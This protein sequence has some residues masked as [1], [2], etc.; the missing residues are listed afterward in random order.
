MNRHTNIARSTSDKVIA[1][2]CGGLAAHLGWSATRLR[3]G[4]AV[5]SLLSAAFPGL[6]V[7][8]V[9]WYLMPSEQRGDRAFRPRR[10][11]E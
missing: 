1:G 5:L 10:P 9:L 6:L 8:A 3:I 2:V 7:Y 4:Y 11:G